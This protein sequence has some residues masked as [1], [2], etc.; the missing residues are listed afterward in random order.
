[1][2]SI[3]LGLC[4]VVA[5]SVSAPVSSQ[6]AVPSVA[7]AISIPIP[8]VSDEIAALKDYV[9]FLLAIGDITRSQATT[10]TSLLNSALLRYNQGRIPAAITLLNT[11][12]SYVWKFAD[13]G[14][15]EGDAEDLDD[16]ASW[17]IFLMQFG[18]N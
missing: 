9:S 15:D 6:A 8:S 17:I 4:A 1:M 7:P 12:R 13:A 2:K 14:M 10:L 16:D 11:F 18:G 3:L 5:F